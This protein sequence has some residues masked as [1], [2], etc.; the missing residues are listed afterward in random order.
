MQLIG[1]KITGGTVDKD[2]HHTKRRDTESVPQDKRCQKRT[3]RLVPESPEVCNQP[4]TDYR[5][6]GKST[7]PRRTG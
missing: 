4:R 7:V 2:S 5:Q 1:S 6:A 3:V